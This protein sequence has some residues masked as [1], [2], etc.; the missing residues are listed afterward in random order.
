MSFIHFA[1][2]GTREP[3]TAQANV[4]REVVKWFCKKHERSAILHTGGA[5]GI[6]QLAA[7]VALRRHAVVVLHLPWFS[8][9]SR[10]VAR[11][12]LRYPDTLKVTTIQSHDTEA[13]ESV[14]KYHPHSASLG[15]GGRM[16]HA[17]NYRIV[18]PLLNGDPVDFVLAFPSPE[19]GGTAQGMRIAKKCGIPLIVEPHIPTMKKQIKEALRDN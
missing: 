17:R 6:D 12:Q 5:P 11:W 1:V 3:T 16:L 13:L 9:E 18:Y 2:I 14:A 10:F 15:S 4:C 19:G 8:F 7:R